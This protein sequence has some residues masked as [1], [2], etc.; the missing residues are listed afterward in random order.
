M[1]TLDE[2]LAALASI[3]GSDPLVQN[4]SGY[5]TIE[6][7]GTSCSKCPFHTTQCT[8]FDDFRSV[9]I[10]SVKVRTYQDAIALY[11]EVFL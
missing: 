9:G 10:V 3:Q 5:Y 6:C 1:K 11:P 7:S 4:D 8:A 2:K